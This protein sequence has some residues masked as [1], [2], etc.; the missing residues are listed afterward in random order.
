MAAELSATQRIIQID[1]RHKIIKCFYSEQKAINTQTKLAF[2]S[3]NYS[4]NAVLKIVTAVIN[5]FLLNKVGH[6][7]TQRYWLIIRSF[8]ALS[9]LELVCPPAR[10]PL[11]VNLLVGPP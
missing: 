5:R 4:G 2:D 1:I 3:I 8:A 6:R 7:I 10:E 11:S 9:M